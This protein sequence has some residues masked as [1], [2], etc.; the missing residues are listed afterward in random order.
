MKACFILA[1]LLATPAFAASVV[2]T[3][4][5]GF[6]ASSFNSAGSWDSSAAPTAGNDY[7]NNGFLLRTPNATNASFTFAGDSLTISGSASF[8]GVNNEALMWKGSGTGAVITVGNLIVNGGQLRHGQG[9]GD[10]FTLAG[11]ISVGPTGM[12][13]AAQGGFDIASAISG[14]SSITVMANGS[15]STAR[16][17]TFSSPSSTFN[18]NLS[19]NNVQSLATF[20]DDAVFNF[21]I[22]SA[23]VNN[24]ISGTGVLSLNG[25]FILDLT[26]AG[27]TLGD[28]WQLVDNATLAETYGSTFTVAG[29]T[30]NGDDT[31]SSGIYQ[32]D[33]A[34][35]LL[36]VVPEPSVALLGG[37][38]MLGMLRR[39]RA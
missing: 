2:M 27:T 3:G 11:N 13:V 20:A 14:N 30:D 35:G 33:E 23:G 10:S 39:R 29:F 12:G 36:S 25:D 1:T 17:V 28:S 38:G 5:D 18:G 31:W 21:L 26:G 4:G 24:S 9:D 34:T 19:L 37:L 7:A 22:G 8:S 15:G 6:G 32:F 16:M